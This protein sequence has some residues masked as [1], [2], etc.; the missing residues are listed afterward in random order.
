MVP[1]RRPHERKDECERDAGAER[2]AIARRAADAARRSA[3]RKVETKAS[4]EARAHEKLQASGVPFVCRQTPAPLA[5][6]PYVF[7]G[8]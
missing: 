5:P 6:A 7:S 8:F 2:L 3:W 1:A 4:I